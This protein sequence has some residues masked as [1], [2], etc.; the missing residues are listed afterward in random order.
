MVIAC[1]ESGWEQNR[2]HKLKRQAAYLRNYVRERGGKVIAL[3]THV[4][5]GWDA[6]WI[7]NA[8][9][10]ARENGAKILFECVNRAARHPAYHSE[11]NFTAQAR[12]SD[13]EDVRYWAKGVELVTVLQPDATP[14]E[15][16]SFQTKRG[17]SISGN[18]GGRPRKRQRT[19][20]PHETIR[21]AMELRAAGS[22]YG[23]I[24]NALDVPRATVQS[25]VKRYLNRGV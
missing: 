21:Q 12:T 11:S 19:I 7:G 8:A 9:D 5:S 17:Q 25:W 22:S 15:E 6:T 3:F 13:L 2:T 4:G 24:A 20:R 23:E 14:E 1:R 16:R 10:E 18:K